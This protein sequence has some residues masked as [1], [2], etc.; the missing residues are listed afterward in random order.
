MI[1]DSKK[2]AEIKKIIEN[3]YKLLSISLIEKRPVLEMVYKQLFLNAPDY[4]KKPKNIKEIEAQQK[5]QKLP[6]NEIREFNLKELNDFFKDLLEKQKNDT[7]TK[8]SGLIKEANLSAQS[9]VIEKLGSPEEI[10][11]TI[12][13]STKNELKQ[14]L[15]DTTK[16]AA[17][18]FERVAVTEIS[19]A[20]GLGSIDRIVDDN[21]DKDLRDVIVYRIPVEDISTCVYCKKFYLESPGV[22]KLYKLSDIMANGSNFG[23]KAVDWKPVMGSTHPN[24]RCSGWIELKPGFKLTKD[25]PSYIGLNAW[26]EYISNKFK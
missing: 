7:L 21:S 22:P 3:N 10:S 6:K 26:N 14:K 5:A 18:N 23:K 25:G 13:I 19:N 11:K 12:E 9:K 4:E 8:F 15:R 1:I 17:R 24:E 16:D 2:L 20:I